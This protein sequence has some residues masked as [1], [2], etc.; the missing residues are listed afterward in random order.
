MRQTI[1]GIGLITSLLVA[2]AV[3]LGQSPPAAS[4]IVVTGNGEAHVSADRA[5]ILVGVQSRAAT[6]VSASSDNARRV[7]AVLD[8]LRAL[9]VGADQLST[10]NYNVSPEV[11]YPPGGGQPPR[12]TGYVV[13]N[14]VRA[15]RLRIEE[16]GRVLDAALAKG[17]NEISGLSLS[18]SKS[19][20][21]RL[22]ALAAAVADARAQ[23][24]VLAR[25]AGGTLGSLIE[26][27]SAQEPIRPI[28]Q[29]VTRMAAAAA[30][31]TPIVSGEHTVTATVTARWTFV[32]GR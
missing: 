19:D 18:S 12:V 22:A 15:D 13:T 2:P 6:A 11:Q 14:S 26:L 5:T 9:G 25:A 32:G 1:V 24:E 30:V 8:T 10:V 20:S 16:I 27:S 29:P 17:A 7:R 23:A 3:A 28:A 31:Q 21:T 4:Q